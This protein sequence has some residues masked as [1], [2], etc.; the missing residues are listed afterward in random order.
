[1]EKYGA[2]VFWCWV[3]HVLVP[4]VHGMQRVEV[5]H[6]RI[7]VFL[8]QDGC[9]GDT[10]KGGIALDHAVVLNAGKGLEAIAIHQKNI[11]C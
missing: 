3:A 1:M 4:A 8:G 11:G 7:P 10:L 9:R 6:V 5:L 2:L